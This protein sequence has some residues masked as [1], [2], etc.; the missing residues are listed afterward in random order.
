MYRGVLL[1]NAVP[2]TDKQQRRILA[3][4]ER[5]T[6]SVSSETKTFILFEEKLP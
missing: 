1:K 3:N 5:K 6:I 2:I 4:S